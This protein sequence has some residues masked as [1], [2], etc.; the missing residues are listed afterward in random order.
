MW[1]LDGFIPT[2]LEA[3]YMADHIYDAKAPKENQ[4]VSV[5]NAGQWFLEDIKTN[6]EGLKMGIYYK[7]NSSGKKEYALVNKG[8]SILG[9]WGNNFQQPLGWSDDMKDSIK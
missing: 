1:I 9:D 5:P 3:A 7:T 4:V 2:P 6:N 8:T